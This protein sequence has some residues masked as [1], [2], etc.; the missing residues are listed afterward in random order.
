[1]SDE[2][3]QTSDALRAR[4][5]AAMT[6]AS[7]SKFFKRVQVYSGKSAAVNE[8]II[9]VGHFGIKGAGE[10]VIDDLDKSFDALVC[11]GKPK[12]MSINGD[13]ILSYFEEDSDP[14]KDI[15]DKSEIKDSGCMYGPEFL[16]WNPSRGFFTFFMS[17]KTLRKDSKSVFSRLRKAANFETRLIKANNYSWHGITCRDCTGFP[18]LPDMEL[19][20]ET[21]ERFLNEK[22]SNVEAAP[23]PAAGG[24]RDR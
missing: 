20:Q 2:L 6:V 16:L 8:G 22:S 12:A 10:D 13:M 7:T 21:M 5:A 19:L 1:M 18:E 4:E 24:G 17:S 14:Y 23:T 15:I 11:A 9:G 3:I